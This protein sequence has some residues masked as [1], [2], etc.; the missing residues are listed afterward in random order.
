MSV[1]PKKLYNYKLYYNYIRPF[2]YSFTSIFLQ[3]LCSYHPLSYP[4]HVYRNPTWS[5][6]GGKHPR[7][8]AVQV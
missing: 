6:P 4:A 2:S 8:K 3:F 1:A 7:A 5:S